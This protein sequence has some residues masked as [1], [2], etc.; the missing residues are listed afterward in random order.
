M[1]VKLDLMAAIRHPICPLSRCG[2]YWEEEETPVVRDGRAVAQF[3]V[4]TLWRRDLTTPVA[5]YSELSDRLFAGD[6]ERL[7]LALD[8]LRQIVVGPAESRF[9]QVFKHRKE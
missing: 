5:W 2:G 7:G 3:N 1:N 6:Y 4:V 8:I 9:L